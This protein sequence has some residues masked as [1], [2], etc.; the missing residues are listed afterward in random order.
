MRVYPSKLAD[1][2]GEHLETGP[3]LPLYQ[4]PNQIN[5]SFVPLLPCP[6]SSGN[7]AFLISSSPLFDSM[8]FGGI[9]DGLPTPKQP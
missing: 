4:Q 7:V 1:Y 9:L 2:I 5:L 6:R 3:K 8:S